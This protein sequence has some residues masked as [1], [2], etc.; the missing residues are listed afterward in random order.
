MTADAWRGIAAEEAD[1][2]TAGV[3]ALLRR[4]ARRLL[5]DLLRP[6]RRAVA[7]IGAL[8]VTAN[9]AALAGPWLVGVGIDRGI[10]PLMHGG[11]VVPL[12][13]IVA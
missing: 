6:H 9:L 1:Q 12:A 7:A 11:D 5:T 2:L 10:P 4:R 13:V 8:V 3:S